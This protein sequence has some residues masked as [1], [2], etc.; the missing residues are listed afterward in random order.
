MVGFSASAR[1]RLLAMAV[2]L[3]QACALG[4]CVTRHDPVLPTAEE[5]DRSCTDL[6][7]AFERAGAAAADRKA[8]AR[9][10]DISIGISAAVLAVTAAA[11]AGVG[12]PLAAIAIQ[13]SRGDFGYAAIAEDR[14]KLRALAVR[15]GCTQGDVQH[16]AVRLEPAP[17]ASEIR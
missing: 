11:T 10:S 14:E 15:K 3:G 5:Y 9:R 8:M 6:V 13:Q 4:G 7:A 1:A 16:Q 12:L 2:V 17:G